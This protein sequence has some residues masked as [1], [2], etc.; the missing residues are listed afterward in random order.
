MVLSNSG[1][2]VFAML[3]EPRIWKPWSLP[4]FW[5]HANL[6]IMV[7][8]MLLEPANLGTMV[9]A[10]RLKLANFGNHGICDGFGNSEFGNHGI[11][12]AF[13]NSEF[14]DH[15]I[16]LLEPAN[17]GTMVFAMVL[18]CTTKFFQP[19]KLR[20][21]AAYYVCTQKVDFQP[22]KLRVSP[23]YHTS[24]LQKLTSSHG[25]SACPRRT[26]FV[27]QKVNFPAR[28]L[29]V[30]VPGVLHLFDKTRLSSH[31]S[32]RRTTSVTQKT[33]RF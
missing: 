6:G 28:K 7:F 8:A 27:P 2:M 19:W 14:G 10:M 9:F 16:M 22:R 33:L 4:C 13:G 12:D 20:V 32:P 23:T 31:G 24:V 15:G 18:E 5:N 21:S 11:C 26:M 1:T 30:S 17:L 3:L 25:S 29:R